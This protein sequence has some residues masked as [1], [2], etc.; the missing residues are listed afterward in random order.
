[1]GSAFPSDTATLSGSAP[2]TGPTGSLVFKLEDASNNVVYTQ[3]DPVNGNGTY[4][5]A[6]PSLPQ[7]L[8]A[9]TYHW[10][11]N[12]GGDSNNISTGD[13]TSATES[14]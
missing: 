8:V 7:S 12:Y 10:V 1:M 5:A 13:F 9:G 6:V 11:A 14:R 4:T 3:T 2:S